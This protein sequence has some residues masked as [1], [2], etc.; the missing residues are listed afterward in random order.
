M[1]TGDNSVDATSH[2]DLQSIAVHK[3]LTLAQRQAVVDAALD[4]SDQDAEKFL[5]KM[6]LRLAR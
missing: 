4:T 6:A 1:Q 2:E 5:K 3:A